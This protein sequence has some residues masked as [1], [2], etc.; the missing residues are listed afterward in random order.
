VAEEYAAAFRGA[1]LAAADEAADA[2]AVAAHVRGSAIREYLVAALDDWALVTA[3]ARLRARLLRI[4]RWADPDPAW[5]DRVRDPVVWG[6]RR[7]LEQLAAEVRE[8]SRAEQPPQLLMTLAALLEEVGGDPAP[9]LR[10]VQRERPGNF[11]LNSALGKVLL[12]TQPAESVGFW[13]AAVVLRP[14][15]PLANFDLGWALE[16]AGQSEEAL[17]VHLRAIALDPEGALAHHGMGTA[18]LSLRRREDAVAA[19]NRATALDP[20]DHAAWNLTAIHRA[21]AGDGAGYRDHCRRM[22]DRFRQTTDPAIAERTA[23]ACLILPLGGPEQKAACEL[24]DRAVAMAQGH[25]VEPLA[26]ATRGLAAYRRARFVDAVAWADRSLSREPG[27]WNREIPAHLVRAMALSR[28]GRRDEAGV[29][30]ARA[31]DLYRAK[32]A[33]PGGAAKGGDWHDKVIC[34]LLRREAEADLLDR[35]FPANPFAR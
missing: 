2:E 13:R 35:D 26:E 3:E 4:A 8:A 29:A 28:L 5:R 9:L 20:D 19:Y 1:G 18:L 22:L 32:I 24:A 21:Q 23:K 11:W 33:N 25:W 17:A 12:E 14:Q 31:S 27:T 7:A 30:L 6:D 10:A 16:K 34:E 15:D